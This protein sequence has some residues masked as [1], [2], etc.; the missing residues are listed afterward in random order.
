MGGGG[1]VVVMRPV[2]HSLGTG[3]TV[4]NWKAQ[5]HLRISNQTQ[6]LW[7]CANTGLDFLIFQEN[8]KT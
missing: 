2:A 6:G 5:S 4:L 1:C 7:P 3:E 8:A